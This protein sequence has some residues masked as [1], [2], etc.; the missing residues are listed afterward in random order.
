MST[1]ASIM[2]ALAYLR[3]GRRPPGQARRRPRRPARGPPDRGRRAPARGR[4]GGGSALRG[5]HALR[6]GSASSASEE[7]QEVETVF[8]D[9]V[10]SRDR[11]AFRSAVEIPTFFLAG[12]ARAADLL[13]V[14]RQGRDDHGDWRFVVDPGD[15]ALGAGRPILVT[16][17]KVSVLSGKRVVIAWKD[18]REARRAVR[19]ALPLLK[20]A[21][22]VLVVAVGE[23][24][25]AGALDVQEHLDGHGI[26]ARTLVHARRESAVA[27][28]LIRAAE[29]EG[30]DLIVAGAYGHSRTREWI[31][32][33]VTRDLLDHAP[34][35]C[36]LAH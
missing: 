14:G 1:Y 24:G 33:G 2:V 23:S 20:A 17:P 22:E 36:L 5:R 21:E 11:V 12:Q 25:R 4:S 6:A 18:A 29:R 19:D 28:E 27:D 13:V 34:I 16:P 7:L 3:P 30:A 32:G 26:K 9:A 10:G 35:P 15:L 8:R 31:L